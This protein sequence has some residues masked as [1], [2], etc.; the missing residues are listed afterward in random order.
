MAERVVDNLET[1]KIDPQDGEA[2]LVI[3]RAINRIVDSLVQ[4]VAVGQP[5]ERIVIC[6]VPDT[7]QCGFELRGLPFQ[8]M[9]LVAGL[10]LAMAQFVTNTVEP[11]LMTNAGRNGDQDQHG[12]DRC[13]RHIGEATAPISFEY[14]AFGDAEHDQ[15]RI[16]AGCPV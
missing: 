7:P 10:G 9:S 8:L 13:N 15:Q 1:I 11:R 6:K 12:A 3:A 16:F 4:Q 2:I 14:R 5:C